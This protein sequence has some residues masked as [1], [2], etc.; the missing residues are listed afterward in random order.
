MEDL[1][2][3]IDKNQDVQCL[4]LD[5]GLALVVEDTRNY[6]SVILSIENSVKLRDWLSAYI[7]LE[8]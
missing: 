1:H 3:A 7:E 5:R 8:K 2:I 6:S 4:L